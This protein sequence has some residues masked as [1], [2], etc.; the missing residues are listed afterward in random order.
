MK[1]WFSIKESFLPLYGVEV[2]ISA[3]VPGSKA[4]DVQPNML[5]DSLVIEC[6]NYHKGDLAYLPGL[7]A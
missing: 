7:E 5:M 6:I 2:Y 1:E 3:L 4:R